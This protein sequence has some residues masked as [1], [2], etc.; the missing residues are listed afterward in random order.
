VSVYQTLQPLYRTLGDR[1]WLAPSCSLLHS[2]VDLA[3]ENKLDEEFESWL[4]SAKQK[5]Q[6]LSLLKSALVNENTAEIA[7]Y[8]R[9]TLARAVS[10]RINNMA[11]Q[12]R[13]SALSVADFTRK[14]TFEVRK[15]AQQAELNLPILPTTTIGSFPQTGDIREH[16]PNGVEKKLMMSNTLV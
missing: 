1:L 5:C 11:V 12:Q 14:E 13:N 9:P 8:S 6:E 7:L 10:T 15:A 4:A 16:V 3:Q 2:P